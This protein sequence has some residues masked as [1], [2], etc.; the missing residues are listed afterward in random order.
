MHKKQTP[1]HS[2]HKSFVIKLSIQKRASPHSNRFEAIEELM[3]TIKRAQCHKLKRTATRI[4]YNDNA[5]NKSIK[6]G[7]VLS[8]KKKIK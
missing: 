7:K 2:N 1:L 4:M 8:R 5:K 3:Q 6:K